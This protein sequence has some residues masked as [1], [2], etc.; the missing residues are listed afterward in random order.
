MAQTRATCCAANARRRVSFTTT[1]LRPRRSVTPIS[2]GRRER[3]RVTT[4]GRFV[5]AVRKG[6]SLGLSRLHR[7]PR[8]IRALLARGRESREGA[9]CAVPGCFGTGG[10][11]M[12]SHTNWPLRR[13]ANAEHRSNGSQ[14]RRLITLP[15]ARGTAVAYAEDREKVF[16]ERTIA[17]RQ[18]SGCMPSVAGSNPVRPP[19]DS[20]VG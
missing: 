18:S 12:R 16:R 11:Q 9:S 2:R 5:F 14:R 6:K 19:L 20:S 10:R 1:D 4:R 13:E 3:P 7:A 17:Q 8:S 15:G